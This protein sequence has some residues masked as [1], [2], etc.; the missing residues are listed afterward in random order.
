M[1]TVERNKVDANVYIDQAI[2]MLKEEYKYISLI[3]GYNG[4]LSQLQYAKESHTASLSSTD[5]EKVYEYFEGLEVVSKAENQS[6]PVQERCQ[7][8]TAV[9]KYYGLPEDINERTVIKPLDF[10]SLVDLL[11]YFDQHKNK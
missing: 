9:I 7:Y 1:N 3:A 6:Q 8:E 5:F 2:E 11:C 4:I 10:G